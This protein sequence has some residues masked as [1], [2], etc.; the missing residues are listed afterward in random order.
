VNTLHKGDDDDD[1]DD[2]DDNNYN[3]CDVDVL[4]CGVPYIC[5]QVNE[6]LNRRYVCSDSY[7]KFIEFKGFHTISYKFVKYGIWCI[8]VSI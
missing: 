4:V 8:V 6:G 3:Y 7:I 1:D 5:I 2:D